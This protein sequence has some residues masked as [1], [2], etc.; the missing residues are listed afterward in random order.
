[1]QIVKG[2]VGVAAILFPF[3]HLLCGA[4]FSFLSHR[5]SRG[6][7]N[8]NLRDPGSLRFSRSVVTK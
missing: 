2:V 1:M 7:K 8:L 3:T 4:S 5:W 6:Y